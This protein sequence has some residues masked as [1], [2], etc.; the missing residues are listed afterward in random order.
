MIKPG[1]YTSEF[2]LCV[3]ACLAIC[4]NKPL[5]FDL[6]DSI[7]AILAAIVSGYAISRGLTKKP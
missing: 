5:G 6:P 2:W 4:L 3:L 7:S 1:I